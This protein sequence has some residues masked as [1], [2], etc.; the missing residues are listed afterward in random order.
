MWESIC[1]CVYLCERV[2]VRKCCVSLCEVWGVVR[3]CLCVYV[4][5]A[6]ISEITQ[7][8]ACTLACL[9]HHYDRVVALFGT[10]PAETNLS[11]A[12]LDEVSWY[13]N[14]LASLGFVVGLRLLSYYFVLRS[15][16]KF[17]NS[18]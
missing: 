9:D 15:A 5:F 10:N 12:G 18:I 3:V 1:L 8:C 16:A 4:R 11:L 17:D 14:L 6:R 2:S 13:G 7:I